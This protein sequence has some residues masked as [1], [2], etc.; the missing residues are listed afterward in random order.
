MLNLGDINKKQRYSNEGI[1]TIAL[2]VIAVGIVI[3]ILSSINAARHS[4]K[5]KGTVNYL[6]TLKKH[7]PEIC[8][9]INSNLTNDPFFFTNKYY[10]PKVSILLS[11]LKERLLL[12]S[13]V[14]GTPE[15]SD[16]DTYESYKVKVHKYF[17]GK[18]IAM[19]Q[20]SGWYDTAGIHKD[21]YYNNGWLDA[22]NVCTL[23]NQIATCCAIDDKVEAKLK[24][25]W[26]LKIR[27]KGSSVVNV[28]DSVLENYISGC[29][30]DLNPDVASKWEYTGFDEDIDEALMDMVQH[31]K[32]YL[33][34]EYGSDNV[35]KIL[36]NTANH[37]N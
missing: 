22:K 33:I 21:T 35:K 12:L 15:P 5:N 20:Q 27:T 8:K 23:F 28:G 24:R 29:F 19:S 18:E 10:M 2:V 37:K 14:L 13:K 32:S 31:L 1:G 17:N 6:Q 11:C 9:Y 34:K 3:N 7:Y 36:N 16:T 4:K 30:Y 26:Q 25:L